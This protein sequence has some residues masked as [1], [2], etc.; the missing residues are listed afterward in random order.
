MVIVFGILD[1]LFILICILIYLSIYYSIIHYDNNFPMGLLFFYLIKPK[2]YLHK[3]QN[4][5]VRKKIEKK[6]R[7]FYCLF[8]LMLIFDICFVIIR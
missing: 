3:I 7:L 2:D 6:L 4:I 1:F 5:E 8:F